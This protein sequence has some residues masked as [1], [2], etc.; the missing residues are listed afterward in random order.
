[1]KDIKA[2]FDIGNDFIKAI[3]F[4][5][6][7]DK[8]IVLAKHME[9]NHWMRKGKI[10]DTEVFAQTINSITDGFIKKLGGDFIDEVFVSVSHPESKIMRIVEQ[11]RIMKEQVTNEDTQH[12]MSVVADIANQ[13]NAETVKI[14]PVYRTV[15]EN[16]NE[17]DPVGMQAK[18][19]ELTADVFLLPKTFLNILLDTFERVGITPNDI[20]PNILGASEIAL[21]YDHKDLG[22]I[23]IDI[24]KNQTSYAI[25]EE[26]YPLGYGVIPLGWEDVTKDISIWLQIDIKEAENIKKNNGLILIEG[27]TVPKDDSLDIHFLSDIISARYE[28]I[29]EKINDHLIE[30]ERDGRLAG[31]VFLLWGWAK[32]P[33]IDALA[34]QTFKLAT[35]FAKDHTLQLG[36]ISSNIQMLNVLGA[37]T[38]WNKFGTTRGGKFGLSLDIFNKIGKFIKDLL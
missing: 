7:N 26:W 32:M 34:K 12:L 16:K 37:Y 18:K 21:D 25:Y 17:K 30:L 2:V 23:L 22:T 20:V 38:R 28:E 14:V 3:V 1:M 5:N 4:A 11:K 33:N 8:D 24:G 15:D 31:G 36:E 13:S 35:F 6:D 19:L 9:P 27:E 10:L 29:F